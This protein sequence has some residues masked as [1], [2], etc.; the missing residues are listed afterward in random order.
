MG[1]LKSQ[2][3]RHPHG[4]LPFSPPTLR[5]PWRRPQR[6]LPLLLRHDPNHELVRDLHVCLKQV[7]R[8]PQANKIYHSLTC[9]PDSPSSSTKN[10]PGR[11][12]SPSPSARAESRG[13]EQPRPRPSGLE[14][15]RTFPIRLRFLTVRR[16]ISLCRVPSSSVDGSSTRSGI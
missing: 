4:N 14:L 2:R 16:C 3:Q 5:P 11:E 9:P 6:L 12:S 13:L 10:T 8:T 7:S 15:T 1:W